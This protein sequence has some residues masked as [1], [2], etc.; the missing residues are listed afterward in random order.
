MGQMGK[1]DVFAVLAPGVYVSFVVYACAMATGSESTES[2][3]DIFQDLVV[4]LQENPLSLL[5]VAFLA[6]LVGSL[7][8]A[9]PVSFAERA[10]PSFEGLKPSFKST[11]PYPSILE[12]VS[13]DLEK[14]YPG[15]GGHVP[16][17]VGLSMKEL[18]SLYNYWK[19]VVC[20]CSESGF[21]YYRSFEIRVRFFAGVIWAALAGILGSLYIAFD[22]GAFLHSALHMFGISSLVFILLGG[23][24]RKVRRQE[25]RILL[26]TYV[27]VL[28]GCQQPPDS[29]LTEGPG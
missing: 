23:R 13:R 18:H 19:S 8:R 5:I 11:F 15:L 17:L 26:I 14:S 21:D 16:K 24:I 20:H 2:L 9:I 6:Y 29:P 12:A 22:Q 28:Q 1:G 7:V 4:N 10:Y 3:W 25:A 27:A